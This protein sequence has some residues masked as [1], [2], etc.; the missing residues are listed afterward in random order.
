MIGR[1]FR[2]PRCHGQ[3]ER[4][5]REKT[6]VYLDHKGRRECAVALRAA[7]QRAAE[8][9]L[10]H[11]VV[12]TTSGVAFRTVVGSLRSAQ[13]IASIARPRLN[14]SGRPWAAFSSPSGG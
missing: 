1:Q 7:A 6:V 9:K 8:L 3:G 12:A 14:G 10:T 13:R 5:M 11:A 4:V 2:R